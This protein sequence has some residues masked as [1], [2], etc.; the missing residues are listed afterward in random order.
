MSV[1][2]VEEIWTIADDEQTELG[3]V[4]AVVV[5]AFG[6]VDVSAIG[7]A[8]GVADAFRLVCVFLLVGVFAVARVAG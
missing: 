2:S 5:E 8:F 4:E 7:L 3:L 1:S 6:I